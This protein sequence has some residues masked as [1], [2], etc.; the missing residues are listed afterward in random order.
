MVE[1]EASWSRLSMEDL[2]YHSTKWSRE[3]DTISAKRSTRVLRPRYM[4]TRA[5]SG[6]D[7]SQAITMVYVFSNC[8]WSVHRDPMS[9]LPYEE[10]FN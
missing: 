10:H 5:R 9:E 3:Y 4:V 8:K 1:D 7:R 6:T 2:R